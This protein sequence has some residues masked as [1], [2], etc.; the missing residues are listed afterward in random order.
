MAETPVIVDKTLEVYARWDARMKASLRP[1]VSEELIA[2]HARSPWGQHSDALERVLNY[3]RRGSERGKYAVLC[4]RP[5]AE[6]RVIAMSGERGKPPRFLDDRRFS[7]ER[8]AV[9]AVFL[10]RLKQLMA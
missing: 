9:H 10:E 6:W 8:E 5:H 7:S 3:F 4:T 2:E 1:L